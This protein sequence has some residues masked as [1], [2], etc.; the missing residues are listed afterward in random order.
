[1]V[2]HGDPVGARRARADPGARRPRDGEVGRR[3]APLLPVPPERGAGGYGPGAVHRLSL[4]ARLDGPGADG[5]RRRRR[6]RAAVVQA[7]VRALPDGRRRPQLR[8]VRVPGHRRVPELDGRD[9]AGLEA[10]LRRGRSPFVDRAARLPARPRLVHGSPTRAQRRRADVGASNGRSRRSRG[11]TSTTCCAAR[12]RC[13][14]MRRSSRIRRTSRHPRSCAASHPTA[15][16]ASAGARGRRRGTWDRDAS[17]A[18]VRLPLAHRFPLLEAVSQIG[19]ASDVLTRE[20][21]V[22]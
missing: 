8:R 16:S 7:V 1:M 22:P 17:G 13:I 21:R 6:S 3:T 15:S 19:A 2:A 14:A 10:M 5:V 9:R 18:W 12:R 11:S 4:R 20:W